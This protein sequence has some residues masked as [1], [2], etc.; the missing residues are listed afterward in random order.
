MIESIEH[1]LSNNTK[2]AMK[3]NKNPA[4]FVKFSFD[5]TSMYCIFYISEI[6]LKNKN[7]F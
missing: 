1:D 3:E 5:V 6:P 7:L 2:E 4:F